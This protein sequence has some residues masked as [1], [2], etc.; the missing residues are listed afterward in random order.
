MGSEKNPSTKKTGNATL[1][2][3]SLPAPIFHADPRV[4][5]KSMTKKRVAFYL[6]SPFLRLQ[7]PVNRKSREKIRRWSVIFHGF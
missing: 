3:P 2:N 5:E 4:I 1:R 6:S 7:E